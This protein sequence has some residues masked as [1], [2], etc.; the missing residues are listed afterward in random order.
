MK[1][2][3]KEGDRVRDRRPGIAGIKGVDTR[4]TVWR[5][6]HSWTYDYFY[7]K[8]DYG[9][10]EGFLAEGGWEVVELVDNDPLP[11]PG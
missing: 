2:I 10:T 11:L 4:G 9:L 5:I 8:W 3:L 1:T 7:I 6:D